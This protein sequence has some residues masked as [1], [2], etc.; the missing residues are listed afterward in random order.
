[1]ELIEHWWHDAD[2]RTQ[3]QEV[4][5]RR[6]LAGGQFEVEHRAGG[7]S[8]SREYATEAEARYIADALRAGIEGW[9][10]LTGRPRV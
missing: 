3:R 9:R 5:I 2:S 4:L 10:N 8:A 6:N 7:R 1:V